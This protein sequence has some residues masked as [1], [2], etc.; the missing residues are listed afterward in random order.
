MLLVSVGTGDGL[1]LSNW[2]A[3]GSVILIL[4][5]NGTRSGGVGAVRTCWGVRRMAI[6]RRTK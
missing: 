4:W 1:V 6:V 5:A 3:D 2:R